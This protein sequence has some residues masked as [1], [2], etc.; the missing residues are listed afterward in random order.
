ML[1]HIIV[2]SFVVALLCASTTNAYYSSRNAIILRQQY[3][4][5]G[6][7]ID[8]RLYSDR[9]KTERSSSGKAPATQSTTTTSSSS[10]GSNK[11]NVD[12]FLE[13]SWK[14]GMQVFTDKNRNQNRHSKSPWWLSEKEEKNPRILPPHR[15]WWREKNFRIDDSSAWTVVNLQVE[16]KRRGLASKGTKSELIERINASYLSHRLTDDNFTIPVYL[17]LPENPNHRCYPEVYEKSQ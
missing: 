15:P 17:P 10:T 8:T 12:K 6:S 4:R 11:E 14:S 3:N 5:F 9:R 16:A 2:V 7:T 13:K 1:L